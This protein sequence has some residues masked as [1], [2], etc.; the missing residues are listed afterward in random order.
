MT[1]EVDREIVARL[2]AAATD[3]SVDRYDRM[4][5]VGATDAE[6]L[7]AGHVLAGLAVKALQDLG[8]LDAPDRPSVLTLDYRQLRELA[9]RQL[10]AANALL[11]L[12]DQLPAWPPQPDRRL[13]DALKVVPAARLQYLADEMRRVGIDLTGES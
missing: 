13:G 11:W 8:V 1:G 7:A 9:R 3:D 2:V 12:A 6:R 4:A 10:L 5:E